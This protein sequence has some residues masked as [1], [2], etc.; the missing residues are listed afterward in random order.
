MKQ[1][2]NRLLAK[3]ADARRRNLYIRTFSVIPLNESTG[4]IQWVNDTMV[5][6]NILQEYYINDKGPGD[7]FLYPI[8]G[9]MS[10]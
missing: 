3:D 9:S 10:G 8:L 1:V 4:M 5:L 2:I 7:D 6:R